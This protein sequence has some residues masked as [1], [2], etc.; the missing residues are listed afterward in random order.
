[1]VWWL[2]KR[3]WCPRCWLPK[4]SSTVLPFGILK[5]G[6]RCNGNGL[7]QI[8]DTQWKIEYLSTR[9]Y[10]TDVIAYICIYIHTIQYLC[11]KLFMVHTVSTFH[12]Q[13]IFN[14]YFNTTTTAD[15]HQLQVTQLYIILHLPV[16][17]TE[18]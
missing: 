17:H 5:I 10:E 9:W 7:A 18:K 15:A 16:V 13:I 8:S 2:E 6:F 1:M 11:T 14:L 12:Y 4:W 3:G